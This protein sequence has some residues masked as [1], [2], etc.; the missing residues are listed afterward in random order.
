MQSYVCRRTAE[1]VQLL[2]HTPEMA[3]IKQLNMT[4]AGLSSQSKAIDPRATGCIRLPNV[5]S[6]TCHIPLQ[7]RAHTT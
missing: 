2:N 3:V 5:P 6:V 4:V 1:R 7:V